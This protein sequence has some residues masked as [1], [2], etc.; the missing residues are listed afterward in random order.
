MI[1][2]IS[3]NDD[4]CHYNQYHDDDHVHPPFCNP[5]YSSNLALASCPSPHLLGK[6]RAREISLPLPLF[7]ISWSFSIFQ[8]NMQSGSKA[9]IIII[10]ISILI[11]VRPLPGNA[12]SQ[13]TLDT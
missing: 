3:D 1:I 10:I 7:C 12:R 6:G 9:L 13:M 5:P 4:N 11:Q 8:C 2:K